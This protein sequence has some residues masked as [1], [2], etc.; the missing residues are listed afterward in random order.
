[1]KSIYKLL[2]VLVF[3]FLFILPNTS[4]ASS[5]VDAGFC[6]GKGPSACSPTVGCSF[7]DPQ[8]V[9]AVPCAG[10]TQANCSLPLCKWDSSTIIDNSSDPNT[11]INNLGANLSLDNPLCPANT[12]NCMT[13]QLLIGKVINSIL[14]VVGSIALIMFIFGGLTWMTSGGSADKIKK[15]RDIIVWSAIGLVIIFAS[16]GLV[17]VLIQNIK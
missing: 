1:M 17:R 2:F 15:G 14:G 13:P 8:C 6:V 9:V 5:C 4:S 11:V 16:Y 3:S 7:Q 10:R 12:P